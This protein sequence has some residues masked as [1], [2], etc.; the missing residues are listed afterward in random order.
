MLSELLACPMERRV[1]LLAEGRF[2]SSELLDLLLEECHAA[3]PFNPSCGNELLAAAIYLA[4]HLDQ[5]PLETERKYRI[6][7]LGGSV[8][9][10]LGDRYGADA[11]FRQAAY[12]EVGRPVRGFLCRGL[13]LLRWDEGRLDEAAALLSHAAF[14]FQKEGSGHEEGACLTLSGLLALERVT[15]LEAAEYF[16]TALLNLDVQSQSW[17]TCGSLLGLALSHLGRG[18]PAEA[19]N[20]REQAWRVYSESLHEDDV[21]L[22]WLEG[23]IAVG[24]GDTT[25]AE[26]LLGSV[27]RKFLTAHRLPEAT[28]TTIDLAQAFAE[29]C[30]RAEAEFLVQELAET[31]K[32]QPGLELALSALRKLLSQTYPGR[33]ERIFFLC[34]GSALRTIFPCQGIYFRPVPFP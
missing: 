9:R 2:H 14:L 13:G 22:R 26:S 20:T 12:M 10:L 3:L 15:F 4:R 7:C 17:L 16:E 28:L 25:E 8:R 33:P 21:W 31:L 6:Y 32:G 11:F 1:A 23:Q 27:R 34:V 24:L 30:R 19:R 29:S 5:V 18:Y